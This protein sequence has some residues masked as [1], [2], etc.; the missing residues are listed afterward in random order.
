MEKIVGRS[1]VR[2]STDVTALKIYGNN[3][4]VEFLRH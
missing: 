1:D 2:Y 4:L 3:R